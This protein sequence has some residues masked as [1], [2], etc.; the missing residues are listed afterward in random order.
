MREVPREWLDFLRE[1]YPAGSRIQLKEMGNDLNPIPPGTMGTLRVI[2]DLG[3]FHVKWDNGRELGVVIG[4][5][6]FSVHPPE[7][8]LLKLYMPLTAD[9]YPRDEWGD[10]SEEGEEWDSRTLLDYGDQILGALIRERAPEEN[11]RGLMRWYGKQ[12]SVDSKVRSAVFT[13]EEKAGRLWGVA[14]CQVVGK[15]TPTELARLKDYLSGQASD[16][17]GENFEQHEIQVDG[18]ELYVHLWNSDDWS[19]R[20]EQERFAPKV[21]KGLPELCFSTL[22]STGQLICI[23]RGGSGYYPSPRD[24][25]NK[26]RNVELADELNENLGVTPAQRQAMEI[27]SMAGWDVPGADPGNYEIQREELEEGGMTLG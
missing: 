3:T 11:E 14:E 19:I 5:D 13:V 1:Q 7:P 16:G 12:D 24:T 9:F 10:T 23:K 25:G 15:L 26:E 6:R 22:A 8:T 17:W 4:E 27:G 21:A 18:G 20:T 2:D